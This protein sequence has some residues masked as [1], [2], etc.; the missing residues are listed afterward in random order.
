MASQRTGRA[1]PDTYFF[2]LVCFAAAEVALHLPFLSLPFFWDELGQFVPAALDILRDGAWVPHS[3]VPNVHPPGV[4]A[5]LASVWHVAGYSIEATRCAMLAM[6]ALTVFFTFLLAV[7]LCRGIPGAPAFAAVLLL[8]VDPLFY[9]QGM[10]AQLDMPAMLFTV[11]ALLLFIEERHLWSALA[12]VALVL[13][14][15]TGALLPLIFFALL[16]YRRNRAAVFYLAPFVVLASW[17]GVLWR[18]TGHIFGDPGFTHYNVAFALH[19]VRIVTCLLRRVWYLGVADFRWIGAIAIWISWK[20]HACFR[21]RAWKVAGGVAAAHVLLVSIL[22]GAE[23]ERYLLPAMPVLYIAMAAAFSRL[24]PPMR[25]IAPALACL[26]LLAGLFVNPPYPF[27]YENNL[28][29][30]DFVELQH[31]AAQ[32]VEKQYPTRTVATA[33]P[34][35]AALR[36]P[37]FGYVG[38]PVATR[39]TSDFRVSTLAHL[40]PQPDSVLV[41][42]SRTWE[43]RWGVL[44]IP[45]VER[46]LRQYYEY[47]PQMDPGE[48]LARFGMHSVAHWTRRG[49]WIEVYARP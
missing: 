34:F 48:I 28:A 25:H 37:D 18:S 21:S 29:L 9:M 15:E 41:V 4:M 40:S 19:P 26:G 31:T 38:K 33:W 13:M 20:R 12:C 11:I 49:Q 17:L 24:A 7:R 36:T 1:R 6:A 10:L 5:Y 47:E 30:A 8:L 14:K 44:A 46:F 3:A 42:Y 2:F 23:L 27:P 45:A 39:E 43:P 22:G 32:F 16:A 35:T